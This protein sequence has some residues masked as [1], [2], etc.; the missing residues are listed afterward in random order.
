MTETEKY[1]MELVKSGKFKVLPDL[2]YVLNLKSGRALK[3]NKINVYMPEK[4]KLGKCATST[5]GMAR[6]VWLFVHG[7]IPNK[8]Y[9]VTKDQSENFAINN[10]KMVD[11]STAMKDMHIRNPDVKQK[12]SEHMRKLGKNT[13]SS[14][15]KLNAAMV[16]ELRKKVKEGTLDVKETCKDYD[17]SIYALRDALNG[18]TYKNATEPPAKIKLSNSKLEIVLP[19]P[20]KPPK[21]PKVKVAKPPKLPKV[22]EKKKKPNKISE[23]T[24][25]FLEYRNKQSKAQATKGLDK[26]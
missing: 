5:I 26:S 16:N 6:V 20:P 22:K 8:M 11:V 17:L 9:V 7:D 21:T 14:R 15:A 3:K 4:R 23:V 24:L 25:K 19:K 1:W 10:L 13:L 18:K 12:C 2:G